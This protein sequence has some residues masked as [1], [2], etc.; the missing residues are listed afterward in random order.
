MSRKP[1]RLEDYPLFYEEIGR[2]RPGQALELEQ[3]KQEAAYE[4]NGSLSEGDVAKL[5][6]DLRR[7][8]KDSSSSNT[9]SQ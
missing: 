9:I 7:P 5:S 6:D 1:D 3:T 4:R 2:N 8:M